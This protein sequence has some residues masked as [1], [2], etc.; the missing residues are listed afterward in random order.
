MMMIDMTMF[1]CSK[2]MHTLRIVYNPY[3]TFKNPYAAIVQF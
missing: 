3:R 1:L 2:D